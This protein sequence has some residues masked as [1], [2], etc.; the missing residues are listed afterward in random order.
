[1]QETRTCKQKKK[2][3]LEINIVNVLR[4]IRKS[5]DKMAFIRDTVCLVL[6]RILIKK[7]MKKKSLRD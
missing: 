3:L 5:I 1:M 2:L 4:K 7:H 6:K